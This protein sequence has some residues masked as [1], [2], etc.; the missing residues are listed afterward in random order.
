MFRL[1]LAA[2]L[3]WFRYAARAD[4]YA[5]FT[6]CGIYSK[7][8]NRDMAWRSPEVKQMAP[9]KVARIL[10]V[11]DEEPMQRALTRI[12][13]QSNYDVR[14]VGSA[15][16][17]VKEALAHRPD[18]LVLDVNLPD[19]TGW[20]VLRQLAANGLTCQML[21]TIVYSAGQPANRRIAEFR[22][23]AFLPKPFPMDAL[24]RLIAKALDRE[25]KE[26]DDLEKAE[27][28]EEAG[29]MTRNE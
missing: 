13:E 14:A 9:R 25:A 10:L 28:I 7:E 19:D 22:P 11:E 1:C 6:A 29:E 4:S 5:V 8:M 2:E 16:E 3:L 27:I 18:V 26:P 20:T 23:M 24:K 12:L 21:P 15:E 17:G